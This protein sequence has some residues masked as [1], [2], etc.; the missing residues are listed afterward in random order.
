M[1]LVFQCNDLIENILHTLPFYIVSSLL[2][3]NKQFYIIGKNIYDIK[4]K[5][6]YNYSYYMLNYINTSIIMRYELSLTQKQNIYQ[7]FNKYLKDLSL[8][9]HWP[10]LVYEPDFCEKFF[11]LSSQFKYY[12]ISHETMF[13][14]LYL[15][16]KEW[17][18][19]FKSIR[20]YLYIQNPREYTLNKLRVLASLKGIKRNYKL[21][22]SELISRLKF[23]NSKIYKLNIL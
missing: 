18:Q 10:I 6:I 20:K 8:N 7:H 4:L 5:D 3:V 13:H 9:N 22:K 11:L 19:L 15:E 1:E 17:F 23:K 21:S 14:P 12:F 16:N 2:P